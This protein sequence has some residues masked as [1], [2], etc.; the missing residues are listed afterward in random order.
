[1]EDSKREITGINFLTMPLYRI[2]G[3]MHDNFK[4]KSRDQWIDK[5]L[6]LEKRIKWS[7]TFFAKVSLV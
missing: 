6:P 2:N 5:C 1:M 4:K 3:Q 7:M